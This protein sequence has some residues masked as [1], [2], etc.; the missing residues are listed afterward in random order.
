MLTIEYDK[1]AKPVADAAAREV[2][3]SVVNMY[4]TSST[5][6][7]YKTSNEILIM[8]FRLCIKDGLIPHEEVTFLY[9][10]KEIYPNSN[11]YLDEWVQGFCGEYEKILCDLLG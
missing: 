10:G 2:A 1:D 4:T 6:M 8:A 5:N 7:H 9:Q 11:G 3:K